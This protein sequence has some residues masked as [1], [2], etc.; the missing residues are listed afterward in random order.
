MYSLRRTVSVRFS[1]TICAALLVIALWAFLGARRVLQESLDRNIAAE[2]HLQ[3]AVI[4]SRLPIAIQPEHE[5]WSSFVR[6]VNRFVVVR[7]AEGVIVQTNTPLA[8]DLP[9]DRAS[10]ERARRGGTAWAGQRWRNGRI[11]SF[12]LAVPAGGRPANDVLQVAASLQPLADASREV[13]FLMLGTVLL[14]VVATV[15]GANWLS[16]TTVAP[17]LEITE[18][19]R[20]IQPSGRQ[21]I[22]AYADMEEFAG[23]VEVLND[24]FQ[25]L[26]RAYDAQRR[27]IADAGHDLRTP[28][29]AMRGAVEVAL[30]GE[31]KP[32]EYRAV[33]ASVLEDVDYLTSIS[34]SLALL[35][36]LETGELA[37]ERGERD[38]GSLVE[39]ATRKTR[40]RDAERVFRCEAGTDDL[41]APVDGELLSIAVNHLLDNTV[42]HTPPGTDVRVTLTGNADTVGIRVD[43]SG[44][45][46]PDDILPNLFEHFYRTDSARTRT[47]AAGLGLTVAA[48]IAHAHGGQILADRSPLG[49][50]RITLTLPRQTPAD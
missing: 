17:V 37:L 50:L 46:I 11:R 6:E 42:K 16:A 13:L 44:P 1:L 26:E 43:D 14:G 32:E 47:G 8:A 9:L 28:L 12:Y 7:N 19:A 39:R 22:T 29:T 40:A 4:S 20:S 31:R 36:R 18:Q 30:R 2:A 23:L 49:G 21:R 15:I 3:T 45:G 41:S 35:A 27:M 38:V 33:L 24:A 34:E 48:A 5:D 25:R 10:F